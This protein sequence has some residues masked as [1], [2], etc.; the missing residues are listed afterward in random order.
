MQYR[1]RATTVCALPIYRALLSTYRWPVEGVEARRRRLLKER[2]I[3]GPNA[4]SPELWNLSILLALLGN[5]CPICEGSAMRFAYYA[6][7]GSS[8]AAEAR[9]AGGESVAAAVWRGS[10]GMD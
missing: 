8:Q 10:L 4:D 7:G 6:G 1:G 9:V 3:K 2:Q 5:N